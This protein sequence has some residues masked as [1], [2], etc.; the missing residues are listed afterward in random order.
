MP[1]Y[2]IFILVKGSHI[3]SIWFFLYKIHDH[4]EIARLSP[5]TKL[6]RDFERIIFPLVPEKSDVKIV[7]ESL[8]IV[9]LEIC[10]YLTKLSMRENFQ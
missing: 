10:L 2:L 5:A 8:P 7:S 6:S 4:L 1:P 3:L 9:R